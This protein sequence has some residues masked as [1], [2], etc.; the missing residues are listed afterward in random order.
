M[1]KSKKSDD[2]VE[3]RPIGE[4]KDPLADGN[5]LENP[6]NT[7]AETHYKVKEKSEDVQAEENASRIA[8]QNA[9]ERAEEHNAHAANVN[10]PHDV[11]NS[12][13]EEQDEA[14]EGREEPGEEP[15]VPAPADVEE[16]VPTPPADEVDDTPEEVEVPER[17]EEQAAED[18]EERQ[19]AVET[20]LETTDK[21]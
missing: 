2:Q 19:D 12:D 7:E 20:A 3:A 5:T 13:A 10:Q 21:P 17:T 4:G 1:S 15:E 11:P 6:T 16:E 18:A 8:G 9:N 14:A